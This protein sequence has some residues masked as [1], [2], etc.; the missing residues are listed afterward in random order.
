MVQIRVCPNGTWSTQSVEQVE[1]T[2][3]RFE[4]FL[5]GLR[6]KA[7]RVNYS[8]GIKYVL[9]DPDAF[10]LLAK[11]DR[12]KAEEKLVDFIKRERGRVA[13][14]TLVNPFAGIKS[15]LDF[16]EVDLN[17]RKIRQ[18]LPSNKKVANDRPPTIE[19]IRK[20]L[21]VCDLRMKVVVLILASSGIRVGAFDGLKVKHLE[22]LQNGT[23]RLKVYA[24]TSD[25][26][27][28]FVSPECVEAIR[29]YF[30]S[31]LRAGE[32]IAPDSPLLRDRWNFEGFR[33]R[34]KLDPSLVRPFSV[35]AIMNRIGFLWV[36]SGV[37]GASIHRGEFQ[38]VHGFRK[39]FRTQASRGI[40]NPWDLELL[41]GHALNYYKPDLAHLESEYFKAVPF[42]TLGEASAIK[43]EMQKKEEEH[44]QQFSE[45]ALGLLKEQ[46]KTELLK[47]EVN[48]LG[49]KLDNFI[50]RGLETAVDGRVVVKRVEAETLSN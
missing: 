4:E 21:S 8:W 48:S 43:V 26:Y 28:T 24:G 29:E 32:K 2:V 46:Q 9:G 40:Q 5:E 7:T 6:T 13:P 17:W 14:S 18:V 49:K 23:G 20:L 41:L 34:S 27:S 15:F 36:K 10:L 3:S 1:E 19:E 37:R 39:F 33:N 44:K 31:R 11:S 38:Q 16:Y 35:K 45:L 47:E 22:F 50:T 25:E 42:L 30:D 12:K